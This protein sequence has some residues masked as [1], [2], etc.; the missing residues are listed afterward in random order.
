[1]A[2]VVRKGTHSP[3]MTHGT[4]PLV[5]GVVTAFDAAYVHQLASYALPFLH[6]TGAD[7][8][9]VFG[10]GPKNDV[11]ALNGRTRSADQRTRSTAHRT[12]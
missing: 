8:K 11:R 1:M 10:R 9:R 12:E 7:V 3:V 6:K 4:Y 2:K 5:N